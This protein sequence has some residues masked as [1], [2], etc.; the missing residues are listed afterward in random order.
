VLRH[1]V[2]SIAHF[3]ILEMPP[4]HVAICK[5]D[6]TSGTLC[7]TS[8]VAGGVIVSGILPLRAT[9]YYLGETA[10]GWV[11]ESNVDY[12]LSISGAF[13]VDCPDPLFVPTALD[14][15]LYAPTLLIKR[16]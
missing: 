13:H 8:Q 10:T 3:H 9:R 15:R 11:A 7:L 1:A 4:L 6:I 14:L 12:K 5:A 16:I 2:A